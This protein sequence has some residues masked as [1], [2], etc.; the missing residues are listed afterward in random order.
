MGI[1]DKL[2][3][4]ALKTGA[5]DGGIMKQFLIGLV[6]VIIFSPLSGN[7]AV[8]GDF[9]QDGKIDLMEA[10]YALQ[11]ASGI[12]PAI[13]DSCLLTGQGAWAGG[14]DYYLCDVVTSAELTCMYHCAY[15]YSRR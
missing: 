14:Q 1:A 10:I 4:P 6:T 9:N 13:D 5:A 7:S 8:M 3:Q 11:V 12:Y 15:I 2:M